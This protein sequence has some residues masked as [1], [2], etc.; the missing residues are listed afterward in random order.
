[1]GKTLLGFD[2]RG[3]AKRISVIVDAAMVYIDKQMN[4]LQGLLPQ[5]VLTPER[6]HFRKAVRELDALIYRVIARCREQGSDA[7][8]LLARLVQARDENGEPMSDVQLR[9]EAVTMLLAGHETTALTLTYAAFLLACHPVAGARLREEID[10]KLAGRSPTMTDL[11]ALPF[12]DAVVKET[13][14][15][16]PPAY[17]I[18]REVVKPFEVGGY[19]VPAGHQVLM[20]PYVMQR[21][22]RYFDEPLSF[23][24]ERWLE[25][26]ASALPRFAYF[27][28]GG[29]P[30]VCIGNHFATMEV[31]LVLC[32]LL[33][34]VELEALPGFELRTKPIV[35]MRPDGGVPMRVK[36]RAPARVAA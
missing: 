6:Y 3:E 1:V 21:D 19:L 4:S 11:P 36:R 26:A 28:F 20:S 29:G 24:S 22:P 23:K 15:L 30:R 32:T 27:P 33:Q 31:A 7:D 34:R 17:V 2:A 13:L 8:H 16:Y 10:R 14:R 25:P 12:L 18:G 9:D 35:T 5:W